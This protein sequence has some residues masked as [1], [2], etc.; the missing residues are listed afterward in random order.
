LRIKRLS[1]LNGARQATGLAVIIDVFR[2]F[3]TDAYVMANGAMRIYPVKTVEKAFELKNQHP[4][5]IL[6]GE[7]EGKQVPGF[8]YGNSPYDVKD[9]DFTGC[10]IIQTTSAGTLGLFNSYSADEILPGSFVIADSIVDYIKLKDPDI[11]SLVAMGWGGRERAPEDESLSEYIE[12]KLKGE[13]PDFPLMKAHIREH[14]QGAKFFD[15]NQPLFKEGDFHCAMD[16][17]RFSF[18]LKLVKGAKPYIIK[19]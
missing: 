5:W 13:K 19:A 12:L 1:L 15:S 7:R 4:S 3:T 18:C 14:P 10:K 6:M 2:A 16:I 9:L 17:N 11:V 8:D